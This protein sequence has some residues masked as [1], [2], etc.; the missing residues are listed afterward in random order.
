MTRLDEF[1]ARS[2]HERHMRHWRDGFFGVAVGA[3]AGLIYSYLFGSPWAIPI[4]TGLLA[5]VFG[6][7]VLRLLC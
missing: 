5:A 1:R 6:G 2:S 3:F 4:T 7:R